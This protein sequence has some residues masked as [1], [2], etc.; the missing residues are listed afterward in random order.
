MRSLDF[1][2]ANHADPARFI[3]TPPPMMAEEYARLFELCA[4]LDAIIEHSQDSIFVTD[5]NG[6]IIKVNRAYE[7]L[8][9]ENRDYLLGMN[10][11]DMEGGLISESCTVKAIAA[12]KT[13]TI[14]QKIFATNRTTHVTTTPIFDENGEIVM[15]ITN[16]R[17]LMEIAALKDRLSDVENLASR[18]RRQI[19]ALR[20][21]HEQADMLVAHDK[22]T[23][24]MLY[25]AE[26]IAKVDA[27]VL[28]LGE[29]GSGKEQ[30]VRYIH[31]AS[32]RNT[33]KL[34][35]INCGALPPNLIESEL[36]GY[37]RGAFTGAN[38]SGKVGFFEAADNGTLFLDE[39]GEL[40]RD[41]QVKLLRVLQEGE[42]FRIGGTT[43]IKT[44]VRLIAATNRDIEDMVRQ[45]LFRSDLYYRLNVTSVTVPPLRERTY[46]IIP[47]ATRFLD[48]C[49]KKYG[50]EKSLSVTAYHALRGHAWPGNVRELKN[51]I[52]QALI[53]CEGDVISENELPFAGRGTPDIPLLDGAAN[54]D[55]I[56]ERV[57]AHY[58]HKAYESHGTIRAAAKAL[59]M[60]PTKFLRKK[61]KLTRADIGPDA[62]G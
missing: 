10:V 28:I 14:E 27:T 55:E 37:E 59:G 61:N 52:E 43:P 4:S 48:E 41:V 23:L 49:N 17:D 35:K 39:I 54:L 18:Y 46:D 58:I 30:L 56:V 9:G 8:S 57:E 5:G 32:N 60:K 29:T 40:P 13:V 7:E 26:K 62:S 12:K 2:P 3:D 50:L 47:L 25:R 11:R 42:F 51:V 34:I 33:G 24:D 21:R 16:N 53:M 20:A 45:G 31:K 38:I 1:L 6:V 15:T 19:E 22:N 36:F 44:N